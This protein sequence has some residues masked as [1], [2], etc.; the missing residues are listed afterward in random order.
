MALIVEDGSGLSTA[1][2]YIS[3]A[4]AD[5]YFTNY[6]RNHASWTGATTANKEQYLREAAQTLD[7]IFITRWKGKRVDGDQALAFPRSSVVTSDGYTVSSTAVPTAIERA[8][9]ELA[10]K[11]LNDDGPSTTTGDTTGIV[12]DA[13]AG[14]NIAEETIKAGPVGESIRYTGEKVSQATFNKVRMILAEFLLP[15][16]SV[17]RA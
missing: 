10:W 14:S 8:A 17:A 3:V 2:S 15:R 7:A 13:E 1:E 5:T 11:H 16:G 4:N 9:C 6:V 12:P